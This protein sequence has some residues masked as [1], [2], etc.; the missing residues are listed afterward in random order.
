MLKCPVFLTEYFWRIQSG[1]PI[2][3]CV[4]CGFTQPNLDEDKILS[5]YERA[6]QAEKE[7]FER[8]ADDVNATDAEVYDATC[9]GLLDAITGKKSPAD[10][11]C[12]GD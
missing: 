8:G 5:R 1:N 7:S 10:T 6:A 11:S 2:R 9:S 12:V 3:P 4:G